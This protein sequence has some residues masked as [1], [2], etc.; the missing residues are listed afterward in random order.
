MLDDSKK[1]LLILIDVIMVSCVLKPVSVSDTSGKV[2]IS[3]LV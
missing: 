2:F 3:E 1:W